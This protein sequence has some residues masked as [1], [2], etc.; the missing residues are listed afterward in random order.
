MFAALVAAALA[1]AVPAPLSTV[2]VAVGARPGPY[3]FLVATGPERGKQTCFVCAQDRKPTAVVFTRRLTPAAGRL[4]ARL[5]AVAAVKA[6]AGLKVWL[7]HLADTADLDEVAAWT[8]THAVKV[9]PAGV[10][11]DRDGP[12]AYKLAPAADV[13]VV[14]FTDRKV[15]A[16]FTFRAGELTDA[17]IPAVVAAVE[18]LVK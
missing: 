4:F 5:D 15:T 10:Y 2:G 17:R 3:S 13:T 1:P 14:V 16:S 11:E 8:R 7:T 12:P 18:K 9:S 6:G